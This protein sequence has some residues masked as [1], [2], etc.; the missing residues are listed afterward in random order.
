MKE[1]QKQKLLPNGYGFNKGQKR[2]HKIKDSLGVYDFYKFYKSKLV[3][4]KNKKVN[5]NTYAKVLTVFF[6]NLT[7]EIATTGKSFHLPFRF[8]IFEI[9]KS[10]SNYKEDK[11]GNIIVGPI[12]WKATNA[13]RDE[14]GN[15]IN[16]IYCSNSHSKGWIAKCVWK[17]YCAVFINKQSYSFRFSNN[18]KTKIR[19]AIEEG[20]LNLD[21]L[22]LKLFEY[23]KS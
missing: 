20:K 10:K 19:N 18:F 4:T 11:K 2:H 9:I 6:D 8:G 1:E 12:D 17:K 15:V 16:I 23:E 3:N 5:R 14:N 7:T 22:P 21:L 13:N